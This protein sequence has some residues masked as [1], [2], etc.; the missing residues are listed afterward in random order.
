MENEIIDDRIVLAN[1][2]TKLGNE[3]FGRVILAGSHGAVYLTYLAVKSGA[4]GIILNDA[5]RARDDSG[6]SGGEYC[7]R[8]DIPFATVGSTSCR[9]GNGR[10]LEMRG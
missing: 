4:R 10:A 7:D 6:I 1:S 2:V 3:C 9:I 8:L 5:G